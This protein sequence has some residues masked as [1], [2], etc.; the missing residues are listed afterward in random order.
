MIDVKVGHLERD[1]NRTL[2]THSAV[3]SDVQNHLFLEGF[4]LH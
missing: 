4:P 3:S 2:G 1:A